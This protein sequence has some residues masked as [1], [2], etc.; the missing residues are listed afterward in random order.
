MGIFGG[1]IA[2]NDVRRALERSAG[3]R[4]QP[5]DGS[6]DLLFYDDFSHGLEGWT[7]S[8]TGVGS[9]IDLSV[10]RKRG[11]E[12]SC[13]MV[14][15]NNAELC[16]LFKPLVFPALGPLGIEASFALDANIATVDVFISISDGTNTTDFIVRASVTAGQLQTWRST[17]AFVN[18]GAISLSTTAGLFHTLKVVIDPVNKLYVRALLDN[19]LFDLT[20]QLPRSQPAA[21]PA[22]MQAGVRITGV[23]ATNTVVFVADP[24][25][26]RNEV[27]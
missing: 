2:P 24:A 26:T 17:V 4:F 5:F 20:G 10:A 21:I 14:G 1:G 25:I 6:G 13:R 23:V 18:V 22:F 27:L 16:T 9:T 11:G 12:F 19:A 15:G 3:G 8:P 7:L